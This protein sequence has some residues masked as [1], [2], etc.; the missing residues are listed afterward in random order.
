MNFE[1]QSTNTRK[2][3]LISFEGG[4]GSGKGTQ[5][6]LYADY[7][8]N[9]LD[10]QT[11]LSGFPR[12]DT[13]TGEIVAAYLRGE[14][15]ENVHPGL[16][17]SLFTF[18]RLANKDEIITWLNDGSVVVL[19]RHSDSNKG[20]Q[21]G[22]LGSDDD[23]IRY[24]DEQD[25]LEHNVLGIPKANKTILFP[26]PAE[27]A[28]K[29]VDQKMARAYTS[30]KRDIH[31]ADPEHLRRAN[32]SYMLL[33]SHEPERFIVID[34]IDES[35]QK[36]RPVADIHQDVINALRPLIEQYLARI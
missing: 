4:D 30:Q 2:G 28:Q 7:L 12:Y 19:D 15:G 9:Q 36:L 11:E 1:Q 13:P 8:K 5:S 31:E 25:H 35:R 3:L 22:Q 23:R 10:I 6:K 20:H 14:F 16:A 21:G 33:A 24:F 26:M 18:D 34:P 17:G 27:L 29:Y 32:E